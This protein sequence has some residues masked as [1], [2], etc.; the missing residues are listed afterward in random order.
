MSN[1]R[2]K[3]YS[4]NSNKIQKHKIIKSQ[5]RGGML[6]FPSFSFKKQINTI[7]QEKLFSIDDDKIPVVGNITNQQAAEQAQ[8][9][10]EQAQQE[11]EKEAVEAQEKAQAKAKEQTE[12]AENGLKQLIEEVSVTMT[13]TKHIYTGTESLEEFIK[14]EKTLTVERKSLA[15]KHMNFFISDA[16]RVR[17]EEQE[18]LLKTLNMAIKKKRELLNNYQKACNTLRPPS[19]SKYVT[20]ILNTIPYIYN[21]RDTRITEL[22]KENTKLNGCLKLINLTLEETQSINQFNKEQHDTKVEIIK[23]NII[24]E[25]FKIDLRLLNQIQDVYEYEYNPIPFFPPSSPTS[26]SS[27]PLIDRTTG[28]QFI[29]SDRTP[30]VQDGIKGGSK[31]RRTSKRH[32]KRRTKRHTQYKKRRHTKKRN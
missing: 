7:P 8:Q 27:Q 10:A 28:K 1:L 11:A 16:S 4:K 29:P 2:K 19:K 5:K 31:K 20:N 32:I 30:S 14:K 6:S 3:K 17:Q 26:P 21:N 12:D 25:R 24:I 15:K 13:G 18:S 9:E 23:T 22:E